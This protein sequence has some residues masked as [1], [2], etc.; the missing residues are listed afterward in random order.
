VNLIA[1]TKYTMP[2]GET[3]LYIGTRYGRLYVQTASHKFLW[4][5]DSN[6]W[7]KEAAPTT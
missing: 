1:G 5:K 6:S 3:V 4:L 7:K 2:N